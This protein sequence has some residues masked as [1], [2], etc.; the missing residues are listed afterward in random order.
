MRRLE[1]WTYRTR[2]FVSNALSSGT[3]MPDTDPTIRAAILHSLKVLSRWTMALFLSILLVFGLQLYQSARQR[4]QIA[5]VADH[6]LDA[7]CTFRLDIQRRY[8]AGV[9]FLVK[10]PD[11]I[12]GISAA[13][14]KRSLD[15]QKS[16]LDALKQLPCDDGQG[17]LDVP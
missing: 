9:D 4:A 3:D 2:F 14:I 10:H 11:G 17:L 1:T 6:T 15:N 12:D 5:R 16:A 7:L 13:D 8:D